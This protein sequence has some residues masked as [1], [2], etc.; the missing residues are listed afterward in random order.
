MRTFQANIFNASGEESSMKLRA[1]TADEVRQYLHEQGFTIKKI[2]EEEKRGLWEKLQGIEVGARI[3]PANRIRL[4]KTLGKMINR[5]Y[6][7][8][9]VIDFL[10]SDEHEKDV[11]KVLR[12]FQ[13]KAEKGYKDYVEF[14]QSAEEY[15][16]QEFFSIIVAGQKTGTVGQNMIDYAEGKAKM[17]EQKGA[18][19]KVLLG[20]SLILG[21]ALAAFVVIVV[22]I[23]PQFL[24]LFGEKLE[25]PLGMKIMVFFSQLAQGYGLVIVGMFVFGGVVLAGAYQ[26]HQEFRFF[27]QRMIL[28]IP[29]FGHLLRMMHT[30]DFLYLMGHLMMKGVDLMQAVRILIDQTTNLCFKSVY[31][32]IEQNLEK[33]RKLEVILREVPSG[34]LLESVAQAMTLGSKGGN[35]GE[36]LHEAYLTYDFQLHTRMSSAIKILGGV[37]AVFSYALIGFMISSLAFTLFKVMENPVAALS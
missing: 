9:S 20:K 28:K 3:K 36:M 29:V 25:L 27:L 17:L 32:A 31:L 33:G 24:K 7:L 12:I 37:M 1:S 23:V 2:L 21:I 35:L 11:L 16:D 8:E 19:T 4:L 26:F 22:V 14:F 34:Y 18:L 15:F 6:A 5:G 30:R 10:L 13:R